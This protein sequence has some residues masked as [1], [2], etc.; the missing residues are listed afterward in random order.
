MIDQLI[1][2]LEE[3]GYS[4]FVPLEKKSC[5]DIAARS[6][7][8]F[9]LLKVFTNIDSFKESQAKALIALASALGAAPLV[10]GEKSKVYELESGVVYDRYGV[11]VVSPKTLIEM[12]GGRQPRKRFYKGRVVAEINSEKLK[13][14]SST[15]L[16][17]EL[18]VTREAIY[19]YKHGGRVEY[20]KAEKL[21]ELLNE[22]LIKDINVF[23]APKSHIQ[24]LSGYLA[25]MHDIGFDVAPVHKGFDAI[26]RKE[27]SLLVDSECSE[28]YAQRKA[29]FV[30]KAAGFFDSHPVIV[31]E[32]SKHEIRGVPIIT[33]REIKDSESAESLTDLVKKRGK[34]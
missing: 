11:T 28:I 16:A 14:V 21:E 27:E 23:H 13:F 9:L 7:Q 22:K 29:K 31:M 19:S 10:V 2:E 4:C 24:P 25:E 17:Q 18:D 8:K 3:A 33:K 30:S 12:L 1:K 5:F 20:N 34:K 26:A 32:S 6:A 15:E